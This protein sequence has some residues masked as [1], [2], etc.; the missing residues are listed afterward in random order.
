MSYENI[1][2]REVAP[3]PSFNPLFLSC[4]DRALKRVLFLSQNVFFLLFFHFNFP[5]QKTVLIAQIFFLCNIYF[6]LI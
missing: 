4:P 6:Y 2:C 3:H 1:L 5:L